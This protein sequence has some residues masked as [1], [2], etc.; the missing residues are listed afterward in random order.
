[1]AEHAAPPQLSVAA[2][3]AWDIVESIGHAL[4]E[5]E[6]ARA[7]LRQL[8]ELAG[9]WGA[10]AAGPL[11]AVRQLAQRAAVLL[12]SPVAG[13]AEGAEPA[14]SDA[15][16][17][18]LMQFVAASTQTLDL[19]A[20]IDRDYVY[21]YVNE[22]H[23]AYWGRR[24][25]EVEGQTVPALVGA[26][27]FESRIRPML[28]RAL[29]GE[30]VV[31]E[32]TAVYVGAGRRHVRVTFMPAREPSGEVFGAVMR[33][34]D[35]HELVETQSELQASVEAL[36]RLA[37][38]Q[39]AFIRTVSHDLRDPLNGICN[40]SRLLLN[41]DEPRLDPKAREFLGH[42]AASG[43]RMD[44]LIVA[45]LDYVRLEAKPLKLQPVSLHEL[46][47]AVQADLGDA[48]ARSGGRV[49]VGAL[50]AVIG[51][52]AL[53]RLV[54][55]N[56]VSNAL[57]YHKAG[58]PPHVQVYDASDAR[59]WRV[60]VQDQGIGIDPADHG[61]LFGLFSRVGEGRQRAGTGL[62]LA[63]ARRIA[64]LHGGRIDLCSTAG[65]GSTFFLCLPRREAAPPPPP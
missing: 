1:M 65:A 42:I 32:T 12:A 48:V 43:T 56:L 52:A 27:A 33:V 15:G 30:L 41:R 4:R 11:P 60:A 37:E 19:Q 2:D 21:R 53:L 6:A 58:E 59:E 63:S 64:E 28:D 34:Q 62:G 8:V 29:A 55:Q 5:A 23:L 20:F 57:K 45:L 51:D 39:Q 17:L 7:L 50:P 44:A 22:R 25:E 49:E 31:W 13:L 35:L 3:G 10:D 26:E 14:G 24:R 46:M 9:G 38:Q 40:L 16:R 54:L 18:R 61:R 36:K 47:A